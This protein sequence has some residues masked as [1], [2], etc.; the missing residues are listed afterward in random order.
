MAEEKT[1]VFIRDSTGLVKNVSFID[2]IGLNISNMSIGGALGLI[3]YIMVVFPAGMTGVNLVYGSLIAFALSIPQ[4]IVYTKMTRAL[5][6]TGG[7]YVWVSRTF[8]GPFGSALSFMGYTMET[9][10]YL[11]LIALAAINAIGSVA[12]AEGHT[13]YLSLAL[14]T[15]IGGNSG[16]QFGIAALIFLIL[17]AVNIFRPKIGYKLVTV[18][19]LFG[20]LCILLAIGTLLSAGHAG[21]VNFMSSLDNSNL[22]YSAVASSYPGST[23]NFAN[24]IFLLP[25]FAIFVYPWIN[26]APAVASEIKGKSA[27]RW[28]VPISALIALVLVTSGFATLYYV[29]GYSFINGALT[30]PSLVYDYTFNFWTLAMGVSSSSILGWIIGIGWILWDIAILAY[31][32]IVISRYLFAQSFDRFLP[33]RMAYISS[34]Y[35]SPVIAHITD[36]VITVALIGL[37]AYF[38][39]GLSALLAGVVAAMIYF[40]FVGLAGAVH[41]A[42]KEKGG[43]RITLIISGI[44]MSVVFL[45]ITYQFFT[46]PTIW[47]TATTS[48]GIPGYDFVYLYVLASF[49]AGLL[50]YFASKRHH[51]KK[52]IDISLAYKEI[53]PD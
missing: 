19:S 42:R 38:Y 43:S 51:L 4:I 33:E 2:A 35:R 21:V 13:S 25:F 36:L 49:V 32:I 39:G 14:P 41:G 16:E 8:G 12:V 50:I 34:K 29:G 3:A 24:T 6:R 20:V 47:G 27:I 53:P 23:F 46:N 40:I 52:G 5:P 44:L 48:F 26:A 9:L 18:F 7:D 30:N 28:N 10:V 37:A 22:T 17:I 1:R 45:Y 31:G 11:A 15:N